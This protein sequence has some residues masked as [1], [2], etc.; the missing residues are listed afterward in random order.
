MSPF[1]KGKP[2]KY[3]VILLHDFVPVEV[4]HFPFLLPQKNAETVTLRS[5]ESRN[6]ATNV[7][8]NKNKNCPSNYITAFSVQAPYWSIT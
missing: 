7:A 6:L 2:G 1:K 4:I 5:F 8:H 3:V